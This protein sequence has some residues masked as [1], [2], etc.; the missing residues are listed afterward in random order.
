MKSNQK[1]MRFCTLDSQDLEFTK[2]PVV[3]ST[4]QQCQWEWR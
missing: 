4:K 2:R 1:I 3:N